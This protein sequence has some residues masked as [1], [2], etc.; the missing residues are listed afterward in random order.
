MALISCPTCGKQISSAALACPNCRRQFTRLQH[1]TVSPA[2]AQ[3]PT[4]YWKIATYT[5]I[6]LLFVCLGVWFY[7][8]PYL[9][10]RDMRSAALNRDAKA[11]CTYIDFPVFKDNLKSELNAKMLAEMNENQELEDNPFSGLAMTFA[12]AIVNNMVDGFVSPAG[13]ERLFKGG[14]DSNQTSQ[15][16]T[17]PAT[18]ATKTFSSD[19]MNEEKGE[20]TTG[21]N[22]Y[23]EFEVSYKPKTGGNSKLIFERRGLW[24]WKLINM[25]LD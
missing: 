22:S 12:P 3:S 20:L 8:T 18:V 1:K 2:Y 10:I 21:Y 13:I 7:L 5:T 17:E 11:F 16:A 15:G 6:A 4:N 14:F 24:R 19:F 23:D 25:K 9:A